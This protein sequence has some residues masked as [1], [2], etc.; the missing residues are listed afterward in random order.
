M[1]RDDG[2]WVKEIGYYRK[3]LDNIFLSV[4][5][6][7]ELTRDRQISLVN[8][9]CHDYAQVSLYFCGDISL[10][11]GRVCCLDEIEDYKFGMDSIL[12][13][14]YRY[15]QFGE[16]FDCGDELMDLYFGYYDGL[17]SGRVDVGKNLNRDLDRVINGLG[18]LIFCRLKGL[19]FSVEGRRTWGEGLPLNVRVGERVFCLTSEE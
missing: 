5:E 10:F 13:G 6:F 11:L 16:L 3:D 2:N 4:R 15:F 19:G 1:D 14:L 17:V 18:K 9:V 7:V 12:L 8:N